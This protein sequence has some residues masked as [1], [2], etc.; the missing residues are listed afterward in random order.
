MSGSDRGTASLGR[1]FFVWA[2]LIAALVWFL[3]GQL[4]QQRNPN[5]KPT[6]EVVGDERIVRLQR[7]RSGQY[8]VLA[9]V[10]GEPVEFLVDTGASGVI[11]PA[12][13]AE[14]EG[15]PKGQV[16]QTYTANGIGRA[17]E[18]EIQSLVIGSIRLGPMRA[19][20][21]ENMPGGYGL[22]GMIALR[23]LDFSQ[24]DGE[25]VLRQTY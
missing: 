9:S 23:Q 6:S 20:V 25:L 5:H 16:F 8:H 13:F 21:A 4:D 22:L 7:N 3:D 12:D 24:R 15:L 18:T 19:A 1:W 10:N 11:L 17:Y 2:I 14:R